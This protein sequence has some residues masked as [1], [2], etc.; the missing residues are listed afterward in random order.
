MAPHT[1]FHVIVVIAQHGYIDKQ[2]CYFIIVHVSLELYRQASISGLGCGL[3]RRCTLIGD[4]NKHD[5]PGP[6]ET[7]GQVGHL[8]YHFWW[9]TGNDVCYD[10]YPR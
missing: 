2:Y 5:L 1:C 4:H 8:P 10:F 7:V 9:S 6:A 3:C